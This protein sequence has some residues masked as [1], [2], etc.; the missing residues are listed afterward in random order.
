MTF[1]KHWTEAKDCV[2]S[3]SR[4]TPPNVPSYQA[5]EKFERGPTGYRRSLLVVTSSQAL[6]ERCEKS[7]EEAGYHIVTTDLGRLAIA[8]LQETAEPPDLVVCDTD[9]LDVRA[10]DVADQ[11]Y[12]R[13]ARVIPISSEKIA[14]SYADSSGFGVQSLVSRVASIL[15]PSYTD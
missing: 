5:D 11:A 3:E 2:V 1:V 13:G 8:Y 6:R 4:H 14:E 15:P 10:V 7:F 12:R 9:L